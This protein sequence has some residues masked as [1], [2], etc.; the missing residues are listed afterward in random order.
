MS[1]N[2]LAVLILI[3][4]I[5]NT[6]ISEAQTNVGGLS[7]K[8]LDATNNETVPFLNIAL[9]RH[10]DTL[11][12]TDYQT[13]VKGAFSIKNL[14]LGTYSIRFSFVGYQSQTVRNIVIDENRSTVNLGD[15]RM[16]S[17]QRMLNEVVIEYQKPTIEV[18]DDKI[19]YNIDQS[20][21]S[22]GS[23]AT[24]ILKNV[25]LVTVD[26]DGKATIAGKRNTRIFIDG[27]PSDYDAKSIGE[28]LSILP[29]DALESIEVITDPSSQ[30]DAD[31]DGIINIVMKKGNKVGLT[32]N[33]STRAGTMGDYNT[34]AFISKKDKK[35]AFTGDIGYV[36]GTYFNKGNSNRSN[37]FTDTTYNNQTNDTE[38]FSDGFNTRFSGNI[39][40]DS[41]Q[42]VRL[43][44]RGGFNDATVGSRSA[45]LYLK[46]NNDL[47]YTRKQKNSS[48]TDRLFYNINTDYYLR[49]KD[50]STLSVGAI[51]ARN[52]NYSDKDFERYFYNPDGSIRSNPT[53]QLNDNEALGNNLDVNLDYKKTYKF[54]RTSLSAGFKGAF[55]SSD[56]SQMVQIWDY[57]SEQFKISPSL[58][59]AFNFSENVYSSYASVRFRVKAWSFRVGSRAEITDVNFNQDNGSNYSIRPYTNLFPSA[60]LNRSF[61]N[62][63]SLGLSFSKRIERPRQYALNPI[64]DDSD[65]QNLRYGNPDLIPSIT[66]QFEL[67][68]SVFDKNW[69][70]S[71][72]LSYSDSKKIIER[73]KTVQEDGGTVTTYENLANSSSL[74]F[75]I[76][77]NFK[78]SKSQNFTGGFT[79]SKIKYNSTMNAAYNRNGYNIKVNLGGNYS[80]GKKTSTELNVTYLRNTAAQGVSSGTIQTQFGVRRNFIKNKMGVRFSAVDPF[81]QNNV[82]SITEGANFY[83]EAFVTRR[84]RN[85]L[86]ALTYRLTKIQKTPAKPVGKK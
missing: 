65:P 2:F 48:G 14:N 50:R 84:T 41:V 34:S 60:A 35:Y 63:Y 19:V 44:A 13:D 78:A 79:L 73:V 23:V 69:S 54:L 49:L 62:K 27:K 3:G 56:E 1:R 80:V 47:N 15:I 55:N 52:T 59:N 83:Q 53:L 37:L 21:F 18:Q 11:K 26:I 66:N 57:T 51:Y 16:S 28:L 81:S 7:G 64:I 82:T 17:D 5:F 85:F 39:D 86:L 25:P 38:R 32:G 33:L 42:K 12:A 24:D 74:N 77:G 22:E 45:N 43:S 10:P 70:I 8:V 58:T 20:I 72:R 30:Y 9:Y 61:G 36:H 67:N 76:F 4:L 40:I 68:F 46:N 29:S 31:G 75:N 6:R 71:P